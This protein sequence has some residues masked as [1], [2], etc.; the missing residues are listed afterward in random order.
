MDS[1]KHNIRLKFFRLETVLFWILLFT[2]NCETLLSQNTS[3]VAERFD[4]FF[5]ESKSA[6]GEENIG[7]SYIAYVNNIKIVF[8]GYGLQFSFVGQKKKGEGESGRKHEIETINKSSGIQF[9]NPSS[10][11]TFKTGGKRSDYFI[12]HGNVISDCFD[13]LIYENVWPNIDLVYFFPAHGGI[14]YN[15]VLKEGAS[16]KDIGFKYRDAQVQ[17]ANNGVML[18]QSS[19]GLMREYPPITFDDKMKLIESNN[20]LNKNILKFEIPSH[21]PSKNYVIDPWIEIVP[22]ITDY[23][24]LPEPY[25]SLWVYF[26]ELIGTGVENAFNRMQIDYDAAGNIYLSRIPG[27]EYTSDLLGTDDYYA[28]GRFFHKYGPD[29]SLIFTIGIEDEYVFTTDVTVNKI[30]QEFYSNHNFQDLDYFSD[31]GILLETESTSI[32]DGEDFGPTELNSLQFDHCSDSLIMG[33]GGSFIDDPTFYG[34]ISTDDFTDWSSFEHD[35]SA[36]L[37]SAKAYNDN[38]DLFLDPY[39]RDYYYLF[40]L[41]SFVATNEQSSLVKSGVDMVIDYQNDGS[42]LPTSE[43]NMHSSQVINGP[44]SNHFSGL[45][46]SQ[47]YL[48]GYNGSSLIRFDKATG[49][50][51][52]EVELGTPTFPGLPTSTWSRTEGLDTDMCGRVYAG[53]QSFIRVFDSLL[54]FIE[55]IPIAGIPQ[56]LYVFGDKIFIAEDYQIETIDLPAS[57]KPWTVS[58]VSPDSCDLCLGSA[59]I[60]FCSTDIPS[61]VSVLWES[62]GETTLLA[63]GLCEGWQRVF[64]TELKNCVDLVYIDSIF[65]NSIVGLCALNVSTEDLS[66]CWGDCVDLIPTVTGDVIG[67]ITYEWSPGE[68]ATEIVNVCPDETITYTITVTDESGATSTSD[69]LITVIA[70]PEVDLGNDTTLCEGEIIILD[71]ENIGLT[72]LWQDGVTTQTYEVDALGEYSV[73]VENVGCVESDTILVS[74]SDLLLDLG[75][76][77]VYC[78]ADFLLVLDA[79]NPGSTYLWQDGSTEQTFTVTETNIYS[80]EVSDELCSVFDE[81]LVTLEDFYIFFSADLLTVCTAEPVAFEDFSSP[82]DQIE[83]WY[84]EFGDGAISTIQNPTHFFTSE[85]TYEVTLTINT[86]SGCETSFT[87][88]DL[89]DVIASPIADFSFSS[90]EFYENELISFVDNS[91]DA[92]SWDW[93]FGDGTSGSTL[94]DPIHSYTN[95]DNYTI[96]LAVRNGVCADTA[97]KNIV[98][99]QEL[100]FYVP[101]TFTPDG[102]N[103]NEGFKPVFTSGFDVY[104]YHLAIFNRWGELIF[105]SY[106][107]AYGW[108]GTYGSQKGLVK[109]GVYI[110]DIEFGDINSD[111]KY[112]ETGHVSVL[113]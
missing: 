21:D 95:F 27:L 50:I 63:S 52:D 82:F 18:M 16:V 94:S 106:D 110:W 57:L 77:L 68:I 48:Y 33:F 78:E 5:V 28:V 14:K 99:K 98:I 10:K 75:P 70:R 55:D 34:S 19:I 46:A 49:A 35:I 4:H 97:Y 87:S 8:S 105:E 67:E 107:A 36:S 62:T 29:G 1:K 85:G 86:I 72:Y 22:A 53:S 20:Y 111:R 59:E 74:Y 44:G 61:N 7:P 60:N 91:A 64:I 65:I 25:D 79:E 54:T 100:L 96:R 113:K 103:F 71:A 40:M 58:E 30:N 109:D 12:A 45:V 39:T 13:T 17:K 73:S 81:V 26:E 108:D 102:D 56:D 76:D 2:L 80:V 92:Y 66:I 15:L 93:D 3:S 112:R 90:S 24:D 89:I 42:F 43:L 47:N 6:M 31:T 88:L 11:I 101:N 37:L 83:S 41:R 51:L 23:D 38:V 104:D 84:W 69:L 9:E 32:L